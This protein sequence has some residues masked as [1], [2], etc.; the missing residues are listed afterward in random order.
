VLKIHHGGRPSILHGDCIQKKLLFWGINSCPDKLSCLII[1]VARCTVLDRVEGKLVC[2]K[3]TMV[4]GHPSYMEIAFRK[5][6]F[7]GA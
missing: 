5:N 4:V 3:F 2:L 1:R 7:S 6:Y